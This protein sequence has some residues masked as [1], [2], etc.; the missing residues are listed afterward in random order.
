MASL[1]Y[2]HP[3]RSNGTD[4]DAAVGDTKIVTVA[5]PTDDLIVAGSSLPSY[6]GWEASAAGGSSSNPT[7]RPRILVYLFRFL[8]ILGSILIDS[9]TF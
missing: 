8:A 6:D 7:R 5:G 4:I 3:V 1:G 9:N 2:R